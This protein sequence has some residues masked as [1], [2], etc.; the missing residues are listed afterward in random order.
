MIAFLAAAS[1]SG[2]VSVA[3]P[4][5]RGGGMSEMIPA[6][7]YDLLFASATP[8]EQEILALLNRLEADLLDANERGA[9][10]YV[11]AEATLARLLCNRIRREIAGTL[12]SDAAKN[13]IDLADRLEMIERALATPKITPDGDTPL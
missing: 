2:C 7:R 6:D 13:L 1:L 11:P 3:W 12:Y 9:M 10:R 4:P 5:A 8:A